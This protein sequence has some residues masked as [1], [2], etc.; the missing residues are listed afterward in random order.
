MGF[1]PERVAEVSTNPD[2]ALPKELLLRGIILQKEPT[3]T[4]ARVSLRNEA[5]RGSSPVDIPPQTTTSQS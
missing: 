3:R 4:T 1:G 2:Q 5:L